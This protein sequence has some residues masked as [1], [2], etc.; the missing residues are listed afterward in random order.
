M[1]TELPKRITKC[2]AVYV[3]FDHILSTM[4]NFRPPE[5]STNMGLYELNILL[6][7][8]RKKGI[9]YTR[10]RDGPWAIQCHQMTVLYTIE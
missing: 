4:V 5:T 2:V 6:S 10:P 8:L 7:L 3:V 1:F 9:M